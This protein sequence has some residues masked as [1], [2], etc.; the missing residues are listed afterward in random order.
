[1]LRYVPFA[2]SM[3]L[4]GLAVWLFLRSDVIE[5]AILAVSAVV[6]WFSTRVLRL[7]IA[8]V[9]AAAPTILFL[10]IVFFIPI[11]YRVD[12]EYF[13]ATAQCIPVLFIAFTI[14]SGVAKHRGRI[15]VKVLAVLL[16]LLLTVGEGAALSGLAVLDSNDATVLQLTITVAALTAGFLSIIVS[17]LINEPTRD[18][19]PQ[20]H[21]HTTNDSS[22]SRPPP[23][24]STADTSRGVNAMHRAGPSVDTSSRPVTVVA[25][26]VIGGLLVW[27]SS[28]R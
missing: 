2:S 7:G 5:A 17:M 6:V 21:D 14:E 10:A 16:A 12:R 19:S 11:E 15:E 22:K 24:L 3:L 26:A 23:S 8:G 9:G 4:G 28:R 1:M 13:A 25:A 27:R 20:H 18:L